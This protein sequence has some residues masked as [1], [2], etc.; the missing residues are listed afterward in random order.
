MLC[1]YWMWISTILGYKIHVSWNLINL[2]LSYVSK[3][4]YKS[5]INKSAIKNKF[6]IPTSAFFSINILLS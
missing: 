1:Y 5:H 6:D 2:I 3:S 4:H